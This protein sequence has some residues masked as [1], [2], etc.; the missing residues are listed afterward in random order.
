M[1]GADDPD[2]RKPLIWDDIVYEDEKAN[3]DPAKPGLLMLLNRIRPS[4]HFYQKLT[5]M[6]KENPELIYGDLNFTIAD[7]EK[8]VLGYSRIKDNN[9]IIVIFNRSGEKQLVIFYR[10]G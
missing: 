5:K 4:F 6:R 7:D 3:Y 8:M 10:I 9:E 1:W 2:C